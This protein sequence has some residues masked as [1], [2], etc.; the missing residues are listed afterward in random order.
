MNGPGNNDNAL[1]LD[2]QR[3]ET[4]S[5]ARARRLLAVLLGRAVYI[6]LIFCL[7]FAG[8]IV[9]LY[10]QP[11]GI[12]R[13]FEATGLTPGGGTE[14]PIALPIEVSQTLQE[15]DVELEPTDIVA[16]GKLLPKDDVITVAPPFGAADARVSELRT[17]VGAKVRQGDVLAVLDN[18]LQL[19]S[20]VDS[21]RAN[22]LVAEAS[23]AQTR[24]QI[25][26][27]EAE[28]RASLERAR[29][30]LENAQTE[31]ERAES[32]FDR[33][34]VT[35]AALEKA[36]SGLS[37][38]E[39]D[40]ER[41]RATL[42]RYESDAPDDQ[43][44]VIVS[45]RNLEAA[46]AELNRAERD[47]TKA[48]VRAPSS[49]TVLGIHVR[50]GEKPGDQGVLDIGDLDE[51]K[52]EIE[53]YQTQI[54]LV[55][56]ADRVEIVADAFDTRLHGEVSEIGLEVGRQTI[57]DDDP[58]ANTDARVVTVTVG[59]DAASSQIASRFTNLEVVARISTEPDP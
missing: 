35:K 24:N 20:A 22:L 25:T 13:F 29:S 12:Q 36:E 44:D 42:S 28:A 19:E 59:L 4:P 51:M 52:A 17:R 10:F 49:G 55:D 15:R 7:I 37:Q 50:P 2:V 9:G 31:F 46:R 11:P 26:S 21:A 5:P 47:L 41:S 14:T 45:L 1:P 16:L 8:G 40:V 48:Y 53:V 54:G 6:P 34:I 43:T 18:L 33:G 23:L 57:T 56:I 39:R 30:V 38:A 27:A 3:S 32:L 58:A